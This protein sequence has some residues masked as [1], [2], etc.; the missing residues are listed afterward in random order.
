MKRTNAIPPAAVERPCDDV[1]PLAVRSGKLRPD[2]PRARKLSLQI[3]GPEMELV[4][5]LMGC[6]PEGVCSASG[7][8]RRCLRAGFP[9]VAAELGLDLGDSGC[10]DTN[11]GNT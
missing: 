3:S 8:A 5:K 4:F 7:I 2:R 1:P 11:G 9:V 10:V 6:L